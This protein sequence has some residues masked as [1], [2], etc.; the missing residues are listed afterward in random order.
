MAGG[1]AQ[2]L[3]FLI[4]LE[5][6]QFVTCMNNNYYS[7]LYP[8][9]AVLKAWVNDDQTSEGIPSKP[10]LRKIVYV[11]SSA[12]LVPSPGYLAYNGT[13]P[14]I[15]SHVGPGTSLTLQQQENAPNALLLTP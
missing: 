8:T 11:N 14:H 2:E 7:S 12:S 15:L 5:P 9:Q 1:T 13:H 3:G 10:K 6:E 4:D